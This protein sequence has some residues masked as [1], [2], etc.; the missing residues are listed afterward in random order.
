MWGIFHGILSIPQ[1]IVMD[2]NDVMARNGGID[3]FLD[4]NDVYPFSYVGD[5]IYGHYV[6]EAITYFCIGGF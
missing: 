4:T 6:F 2:L 5:K 3:A 1:N